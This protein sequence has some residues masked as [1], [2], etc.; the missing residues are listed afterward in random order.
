VLLETYHPRQVVITD[1]LRGCWYWDT[2]R[3]HTGQHLHQPAF[4]T[5]VVDTTGAGDV[6]HGAYLYA[7]L[8]GWPTR[9]CLAFA[10]ATAALKCRKLGGRAG[11]PTRPQV[12]AFLGRRPAR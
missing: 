11:I 7:Y 6:F 2:D 9:R 3:R 10:S 12:E 4:E 5:N 1:G 8:Q